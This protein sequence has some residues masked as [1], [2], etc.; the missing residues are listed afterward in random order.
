MTPT[1][2]SQY[3]DLFRTHEAEIIKGCGSDPL[4]NMRL[5][6]WAALTSSAMELPRKG[7][8]GYS[9]LS[10]NDMF[11][12]DYG[13]NI[14]RLQA[15]ADASAA[16]R[17]DVPRLTTALGIVVNDTPHF[18]RITA[19]WLPEGVWFGSLA[20]FGREKPTI[21]ETYYG[22][23][24]PLRRAEVALNTLLAQDG[25]V[26]HIPKGVK[27]EKPLQV[28]NLLSAAAN[29][30]AV[31]RMMVILEAGAEATLLVCDHT[32]DCDHQYL[33]S[34]V[35]EVFVGRGAKL[36]IYDLE[37]SSPETSR[38]AGMYVHQE[39]DSQL[40]LRGATLWCGLT[41]NDYEIALAGSGAEVNL[42][43][44]VTGSGSSVADIHTNVSHQVS[45]CTSR[46]L[47]KFALP[48]AS[49]GSFEGRVYVA[50]G[51]TATDASQTCRNILVGPDSR[52][53]TEPQLEIYCDDVKASHGAAT[54]QLSEE[55]L[56][57]MRQRGIPETEARTMLLQAFMA[58]V[59][60]TFE[61]DGLTD[62]LR[63][64]VEKRLS[65]SGP[66]PCETC[67]ATCNRS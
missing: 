47:F 27:V 56:F 35:A 65:G 67:A 38:C 11:M 36:S 66:E 63:H 57:Y 40:R 54:G 10:L 15:S 59:V 19:P 58:D 33:A 43:G 22:S 64:L 16:F 41:R 31:R 1:A 62:R 29:V 52:M 25:V 44:L 18:G 55:A 21:L 17:R 51:A 53:H 32:M 20:Q 30:M 34:S 14:T 60:D 42:S 12:P 3:L 7:D 49:R 39:A 5:A 6:A 45:H 23:I 8:E 28:V 61:M 4:D 9:S 37:E 2:L 48:E 24:A 13:L 26:I 50:H 46:Q